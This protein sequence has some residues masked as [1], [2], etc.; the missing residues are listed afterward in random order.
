MRSET[1]C[2]SFELSKKPVSYQ[3]QKKTLNPSAINL[4]LNKVAKIHYILLSLIFSIL[5]PIKESEKAISTN[6]R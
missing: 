2:V 3:L 1:T 5:K 6:A 4:Y